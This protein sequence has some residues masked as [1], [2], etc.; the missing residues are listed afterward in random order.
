MSKSP[1]EQAAQLIAKA[2]ALLIAA[3]A[4]MGVDSGLPDFRGDEGFWR[5]YPA[6]G[7]AGIQFSAIANPHAFRRDPKRA[8]G[9]YGH[10]LSLYRR[11]VPHEG[12][13]ILK[14]LADH[15]PHGAFVVT[16]NVDGQFQ[17]AGFDPAR[18]LEIHGSIHHLQCASPCCERVWPADDILPSTDEAACMWLGEL[19]ACPYCGGLARPN[20][21]M[22]YDETWI[23]SRQ[24]L[25]RWNWDAW[26][27]SARRMVVIECGA[28]IDIPSIR[29]LSL[30]QQCP[31]IRINP[32][33][34]SLPEGTGVCLPMGAKAALEQIRDMLLVLAPGDRGE[35]TGKCGEGD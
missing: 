17:Q 25:Q 8:W 21:L 7:E 1:I 19:P 9:F 33:H 30:A 28:G 11:T 4:G 5:A 3:G 16:S 20:I 26:R 34:S 23:S 24:S 12:F 6:L 15:M 2:D 14:A 31:V 18:I 32:R 35:I 13:A 29:H 27:S 10:R 22:F